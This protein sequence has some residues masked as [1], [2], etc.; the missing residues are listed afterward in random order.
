MKSL[1]IKVLLIEDDADDVL[2]LREYLAEVENFQFEIS[3]EPDLAL[4]R[5]KMVEGDY[6]I[7]LIDYRLGN[8]SGLDIIKFIHDKRILTPAIILTG[9]DDIKVDIDA[10]RFGA[11]DYLV[12]TELN[13]FLLERSIRYALS[14]ANILRELDEKEKKYRSLFERSI[15]PIF[16]ATNKFMLMDVNDSFLKF[17]GYT[18]SEGQTMT[19]SDIFARVEDYQYFKNTLTESE[20]IKDFEVN[21]VTKTGAHKT[22][23]LNCVFIPNQ[24]SEFCCYQGIL[25]DLTQRKQAENDM[26]LAERLAITGKIARTMAHEVRNPLTNLNLAL[27]QLRG[28]LPANNEAVQLYGGIIERNALRI[29]QL[30]TEML[31]SSKPKELQVELISINEILDDTIG[32]AIDRIKLRKVELLISYQND[33]PRIL[34]DKNKI[35]IALLNIIVNAIE[36]MPPEKGVLKIEASMN[37]KI[38]TLSIADN[39][40]GIPSEDLGKLFDPFF[41]GKPSGMGL[42]LTSTKNILNSHNAQV[43]VTSEVNKG[44]TFF[45]YFKL[46]E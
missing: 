21:I 11:S 13:P 8:E 9:H 25:H 15:D 7:F 16:L 46:A 44:T 18:R 12:K 2:L 30:V 36:A 6:Q 33:L 43:E 3:W 24:V 27:D 29:E 22:G 39:G 5:K 31:N 28:E 14:H 20:Q 40:K 23:L 4:A 41:T 35:Q 19:M 26:L 42:G 32:Q 17:C 1:P 37:E 34:V 45:I 10:S 38:L